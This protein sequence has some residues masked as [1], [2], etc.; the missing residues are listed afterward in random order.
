MPPY[1]NNNINTQK[2]NNQ[3][4]FP[5]TA[6]NTEKEVDPIMNFLITLFIISVLLSAGVYFYNYKLG[7]DLKNKEAYIEGLASGVKDI[8]IDDMNSFYNK[9]K[10]TVLKEENKNI[11]NS[12]LDYLSYVVIP[13]VYFTSF[14]F[15]SSSDGGHAIVNITGE[16]STLERAIKQ[17]DSF[18]SSPYN[19][20]MLF[21]P[22]KDPVKM[23]SF[24]KSGKI[25]K[26]A[27]S[28]KVKTNVP[29]LL[30]SNFN[31]E[32][33]SINDSD[34]N[35]LLDNKINTT[36]PA[37]SRVIDLTGLGTTT[38]STTTNTRLGTSTS[39]IR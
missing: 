7:K 3:N 12:V 21:E 22:I 24:G 31:S 1:R 34:I 14:N 9:Y 36:L 15:V 10:L 38:N 19:K 29:E 2:D 23:E 25:Y 18:K 32:E 11:I 8:N 33:D 28:I 13:G 39:A 30:K 17:M 26:F 27:V 37:S 16:A 5:V 20:N 6:T 35:I 4:L